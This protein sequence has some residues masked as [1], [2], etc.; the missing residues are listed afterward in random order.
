M[1]FHAQYS[2]IIV[3]VKN[4]YSRVTSDMM[5][6]SYKRLVTHNINY[7]CNKFCPKQQLTQKLA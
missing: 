2:F 3:A 6:R 1:W 5:I 4:I 7:L